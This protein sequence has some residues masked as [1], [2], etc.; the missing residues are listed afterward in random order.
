MQHAAGLELGQ[1][2]VGVVESA[3]EQLAAVVYEV[4]GSEI[5]LY[6]WLLELQLFAGDLR[7]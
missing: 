2:G 7:H 3:A 5:G 4:E 6:Y 1:L